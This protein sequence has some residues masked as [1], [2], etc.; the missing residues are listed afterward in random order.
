MY[1]AD[2]TRRKNKEKGSYVGRDRLTLKLVILALW[3]SPLPTHRLSLLSPEVSPKSC[4]H[5]CGPSPSTSQQLSASSY[6]L[7][8]PLFIQPGFQVFWVRSPIGS[9]HP[10][11]GQQPSGELTPQAACTHLQGKNVE[12]ELCWRFCISRNVGSMTL[13]STSNP[14][15]SQG[16]PVCRN[17]IRYS[18]ILDPTAKAAD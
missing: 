13:N 8:F 18:H 9:P 1:A 5:I 6:Q 12:G 14:E 10:A 17:T 2:A 16:I 11:I 7:E 15:K 4:L 3:L